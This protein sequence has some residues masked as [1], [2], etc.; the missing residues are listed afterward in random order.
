MRECQWKN[1]VKNEKLRNF[2]TEFLPGIMKPF[3]STHDILEGIKSGN[4]FGFVICDVRTPD[5]ILNKIRWINFPP[6][7]R[8]ESIDETLLTPYMKER[9]KERGYKLPQVSPI[10]TFHGKQLLLYTPLAKFY[11]ELGLELE[12]ITSFIQY[13]ESHVLKNF[14]RKITDGRINAKKRKNSELELAYKVIGNSG[15]GKLGESVKKYTRTKLVSDER[16]KI[17]IKSAFFKDFHPLS[18][19]DGEHEIS[20]VNM[21]PKSVTDDKPLPMAVAILQLSKLHFLR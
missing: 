11:L 16:L 12:N 15:Y 18:T 14:V 9:V 7:I 19:E 21:Q 2:E 13:K 17:D 6:V 4:L 20:E 10:Q 8:R 3:A 5:H 1:K